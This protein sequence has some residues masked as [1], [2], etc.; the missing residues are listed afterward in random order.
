MRRRLS[1]P[2][3]F[4]FAIGCAEGSDLDGGGGSPSDDGNQGAGSGDG[5]GTTSS[6]KSSSSVT[7]TSTATS[8]STSTGNMGGG[9][10]SGETCPN[11]TIDAGE[12]CD[13]ANLNGATCTSI[14]QGFTGGAL[15]CADDCTYDTTECIAPPDCGNGMI[16]AGEQCD[17]ALLNGGTCQTQGFAS[18]TITCGSG[19][20]YNTGQCYTCGNGQ[21]ENAEECDGTNFG[22]MTCLSLGH[23]GGLLSCAAN[24]L[25]IN[26]NA[27]SDCGDNVIESPEVCDGA[28]LGG[29][30]CQSQGFSGG[31]LTCNAA[32]SAFNTAGCTSCTITN[33]L[34]VNPGFDSGPFGGG[35][36]ESSTNF[37]TPVCNTGCGL[38]GGTGPHAGAYWAWFGGTTTADEIATVSR[39]VVIPAGM[40]TL[41]FQF[42]LP[43]CESTGVASDL[44]VVSIDGTILYQTSNADPTCGQPG[45]QLLTF[46]VTPWA[47]GGIHNIQIQGATFDY[48]TATNFMVDS[49]ELMACQ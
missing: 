41:R 35:W 6:T 46:D 34:T 5:G 45:Y 8:T 39:S 21:I 29:Q 20:Q 10:G 14:G 23:D 18:G 2:L 19:C 47:N 9:G 22:G 1:A 48:F 30:T 12:D 36:A 3:L 15:S 33:I 16:D 7:S 49:V 24:C 42:D 40:A 4:L 38:G 28:A 25:S 17:G 37:Q 43:S 32:C 26:Q 11:G 13:G 27:C 31:T 44:F